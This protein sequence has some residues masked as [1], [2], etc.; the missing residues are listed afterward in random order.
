MSCRGSEKG[1]KRAVINS[2]T[3]QKLGGYGKRNNDG[4]SFKIFLFKKIMTL[5]CTKFGNLE[6]GNLEF[7]FGKRELGKCSTL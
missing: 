3:L 7:R 4:I 5:I 1:Q 6:R 2:Q